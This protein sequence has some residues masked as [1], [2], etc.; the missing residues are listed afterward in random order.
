MMMPDSRGLTRGYMPYQDPVYSQPKKLPATHFHN[1]ACGPLRKL[2]YLCRRC[3]MML[4]VLYL[5]HFVFCMLCFFLLFLSG[6]FFSFLILP[7]LLIYC[8]F[9]SYFTLDKL[10]F[11][12]LSSSHNP[13]ILS[14][15]IYLNHLL[16]PNTV[17]ITLFITV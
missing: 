13:L 4:P 11:S 14:F 15:S 9:F 3:T 16:L 5:S 17:Y 2:I 10:I 7:S 8:F 12:C 1:A 6:V